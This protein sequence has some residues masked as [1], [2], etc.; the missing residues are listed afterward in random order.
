MTT[1]A[2]LA[3]PPRMRLVRVLLV[4]AFVLASACAETP[5]CVDRGSAGRPSI[6]VECNAGKVAVCSTATYDPATGEGSYD[7]NTGALVKVPATVGGTQLGCDAYPN[8]PGT[9]F[10]RPAPSCP[11]AGQ[12]AVC[13][14]GAQPVCVVGRQEALMAPTTATPDAGMP[15]G[16]T[17]EEDAGSPDAGTSDTDAGPD[18]GT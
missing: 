12:A 17:P 11:G 2:R 6:V 8:Y 5:R 15:D 14:G 13:P 18:A 1:F 10:C 3:Y 16:G 9:T 4:S 7:P